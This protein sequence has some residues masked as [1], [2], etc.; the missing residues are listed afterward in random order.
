MIVLLPYIIIITYSLKFSR[1]KIFVDFVVFEAPH[2]NF[3][4]ENFNKLANPMLQ[5]I[6]TVGALQWCTEHTVNASK[7]VNNV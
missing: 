5:L 4:L 6:Y 3:I 2:E 1:T 7:R